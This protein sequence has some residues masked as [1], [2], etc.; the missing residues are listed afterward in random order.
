M[1]QSSAAAE[2][3]GRAP[4]QRGSCCTDDDRRGQRLGPGLVERLGAASAHESKLESDALR[5]PIRVSA[6]L[7][8]IPWP[9]SALSA[10]TPGSR[11]VGIT[12]LCAAR[13]SNP[14]PAD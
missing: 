5:C 14:E 1:A 3:A 11:H 8:L 7:F 10:P 9:M 12:T 13:D 4:A 6:R 2:E